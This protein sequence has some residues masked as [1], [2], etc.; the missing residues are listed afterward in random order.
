MLRIVDELGEDYLFPAAFFV[1]IDRTRLRVPL[2][3]VGHSRPVCLSDVVEE[4]AP[5]PW[6]GPSALGVWGRT[7][8]LARALP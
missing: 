7:G 8:T 2:P 4:A 6:L 3:A 5:R 1:P